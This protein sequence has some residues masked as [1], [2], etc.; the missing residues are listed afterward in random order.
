MRDVA[1]ARR[2]RWADIVVMVAG[3]WVTGWAF[4]SPIVPSPEVGAVRDFAGWWAVSAI[5]GLTAFA[6][7]LVTFRSTAVARVMLVIAAAVLLVGVFLFERIT[8]S[9]FSRIIVP[10]ILMLLAAPFIGPMP[11]PEEEGRSRTQRL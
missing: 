10:A 4:W 6:S 11:T 7:V 8:V 1:T 5:S 9:A 3:L 2:Q